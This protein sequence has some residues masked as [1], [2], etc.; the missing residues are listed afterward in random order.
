MTPVWLVPPD[1]F[2]S[3]LFFDPGV[4][5]HLRLRL[6]DRLTLVLDE[7]AW[8]ER[9]LGGRRITVFSVEGWLTCAHPR[10]RSASIASTARLLPTASPLR[11]PAAS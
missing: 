9:A 8:P 4:V 1:P 11:A 5:E 2:S 3:R 6:G 10:K 7:G